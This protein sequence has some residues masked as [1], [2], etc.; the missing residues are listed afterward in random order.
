MN[1]AQIRP[2][3][4]ANGEGIRVTIFLTGCNFNCKGCFNKEYQDFNYGK[5]WKEETTREVIT[6]LKNENTVGLT[7]LGGEPMEHAKELL[8]II[9]EIRTYMREEQDIWIYSGYTLEQI[10]RDKEKLDLL[11]ECDIIVDGLYKEELKDL[12]L[13]FRGSSNQRII[14]I[15]EGI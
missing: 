3:D 10:K 1:Y 7:L 12:T 2:F 5:A 8:P 9:K 4:V 14:N 13:R 15:K 6:Y 11:L